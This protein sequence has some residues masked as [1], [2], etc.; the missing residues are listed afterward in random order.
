[1]QAARDGF[2]VRGM[3]RGLMVVMVVL[4]LG[5]GLAGK[6]LTDYLQDQLLAR[7]YEGDPL[8]MDVRDYRCKQR[9]PRSGET[10]ILFPERLMPDDPAFKRVYRYDS[11]GNL[12]EVE[13]RR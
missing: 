6:Q 10:I 1:L 4:A 3:D 5:L 7:E 12:I 2:T 9:Q 8:C 13:E 11:R